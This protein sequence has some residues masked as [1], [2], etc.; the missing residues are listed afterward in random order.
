MVQE[1]STGGK[2]AE[3]AASTPPAM[4]TAKAAARAVVTERDGFDL[5]FSLLT[6][7]PG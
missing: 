1:D 6:P 4:E 7:V 5:V 3:P 2:V